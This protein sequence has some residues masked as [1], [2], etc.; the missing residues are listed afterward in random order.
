MD[1]LTP[2]QT[3]N[4]FN[5]LDKSKV[6]IERLRGQISKLVKEQMIFENLHFDSE[7]MGGT[8][9]LSL[10]VNVFLSSAV[11]DGCITKPLL[12]REVLN[13]LMKEVEL[14]FERRS[15][16]HVLSRKK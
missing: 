7:G 4:L 6:I 1:N 8:V 14:D 9:R 11:Y 13:Q 3:Q 2:K 10:C 16:S 15:K 5:E 12:R